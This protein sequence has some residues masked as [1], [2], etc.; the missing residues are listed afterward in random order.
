MAKGRLSMSGAL[1]GEKG[2]KSFGVAESAAGR[3]EGQALAAVLIRWPGGT[4]GERLVGRVERTVGSGAG[5]VLAGLRVKRLQRR[6][7]QMASS[8]KRRALGK[9]ALRIGEDHGLAG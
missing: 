5:G 8:R 1:F 2:G 4:S 9:R 6:C 7:G 3:A